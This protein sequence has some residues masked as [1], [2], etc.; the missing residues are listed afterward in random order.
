MAISRGS[1]RH[2]IFENIWDFLKSFIRPR[3]LAGASELE[4]RELKAA[5]QQMFKGGHVNL[6]PFAR[7]SWYAILKGMNLPE[8][9]KILMTP[10]TIGPMVEV[11]ESLGYE[12]VFVD[13]ETHTFGPCLDDLRKKIQ[14]GATCF[15]LTHLFGYVS[16]VDEAVKLCREAG[17]FVVE[18]ISHNLGSELNGVLVGQWGD[19]AIYSASLLKYVDGYNGAFTITK[20]KQ[21]ADEIDK[22]S[23]SLQPPNARRVRAVVLKTLIWNLALGRWLFKFVTWPLLRVLKLLSRETFD[24]LLGPGIPFVRSE[25]LPSFYFEEITVLQCQVML[26]NLKQLP[27]RLQARREMA[28]RLIDAIYSCSGSKNRRTTSKLE[29]Q[30]FNTYWQF[31]VQVRTTSA[32]RDEL[33]AIGVETNTT[34]LRDLA[35]EDGVDLIGARALKQQYIF[36]PL[37]QHLSESDYRRIINHLVKTFNFEAENFKSLE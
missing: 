12:V 10:I 29:S 18:D 3:E 20:N 33:F 21:L 17:V 4:Q 31:A 30:T 16:R 36:I 35:F 14:S 28:S 34:N 23:R 6:F 37:H 15:L 26:R 32:A 1:V 2:R 8:K 19:V 13:I 22:F 27:E 24:R 5:V 25:K 9:S 11:I 7:T